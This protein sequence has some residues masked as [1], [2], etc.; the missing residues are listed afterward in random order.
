MNGNLGEQLT[1]NPTCLSWKIRLKIVN[2]IASVITYLHTKFPRPIIHRDINPKNIHLDQDFSAKLSGFMLCMTLPEGETQVENEPMLGTVGYIAAELIYGVYSEKS[3]VFGF[4]SLL[5][6]L[7]TGMRYG[8]SKRLIKCYDYCT[9]SYVRNHTMNEIVEIVDPTILAKAEAVGV[10]GGEGVHHH[11]Q[12]HAVF[13]LILRCHR[14]NAEERPIMLDVA[15]Q[16]KQI[17][18]YYRP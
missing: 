12:F 10:G 5:L 16:L 6:D 2:E 15:K 13:E 3:D 9:P 4:G 8:D 1:S 18:R 11:H 17:Q 14:R 7:L